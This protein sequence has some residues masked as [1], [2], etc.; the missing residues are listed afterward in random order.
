MEYLCTQP[1]AEDGITTKLKKINLV[2][3]TSPELSV[4]QVQSTPTDP[5]QDESTSSIEASEPAK[6]NLGDH[7]EQ[8]QQLFDLDA[9]FRSREVNA[10]NR[11]VHRRRMIGKLRT[12]SSDSEETSD[13]E[14]DE[15]NK[16]KSPLPVSRSPLTPTMRA[17]DPH[18]T[19][20]TAPESSTSTPD[21]S[22][23][24]PDPLTSP[25]NRPGSTIGS[26]PAPDSTSLDS[27]TPIIPTV[28]LAQ[29]PTPQQSEFKRPAPL[30]NRRK[31]EV[32]LR[33]VMEEAFARRA[34][35]GEERESVGQLFGTASKPT[36]TPPVPINKRERQPSPV[37]TSFLHAK[38][39]RI[40]T[41]ERT[42]GDVPT[43]EDAV[44]PN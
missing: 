15:N 5:I 30:L 38:K 24:T 43:T 2:R 16:L 13:Q 3:K 28:V 44:S 11:G 10:P 41:E 35:S 31:G 23:S 20:I 25:F 9:V 34:N 32:Q 36:E 7:I 8:S 29:L 37:P 22:T 18:T 39:P 40:G 42:V 17:V 19:P 27:I 6:D 33:S 14:I 12:D 4:T 26:T 1:I 21:P